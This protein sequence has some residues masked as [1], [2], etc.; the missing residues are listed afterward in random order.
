MIKRK[1]FGLF[2][3][4]FQR[5]WL[6]RFESER[7]GTGSKT[8][9]LPTEQ[10]HFASIADPLQKGR[11]RKEVCGPLNLFHVVWFAINQ[12][13]AWRGWILCHLNHCREGIGYNQR[14]IVSRINAR[15]SHPVFRTDASAKNADPRLSP[16]SQ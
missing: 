2:L 7:V 8:G 6:A 13:D 15:S 10:L 12:Y 16:S 11:F 14:E 1:G 5:G 3:V 9:R 4:Y